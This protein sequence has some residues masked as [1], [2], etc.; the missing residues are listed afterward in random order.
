[1]PLFGSK[2]KKE[3]FIGVD[4]GMSG[5]KLVELVNEKK[6]AQ[7][8][9]YAFVD[10]PGV[11]KLYLED[12]E[13]TAALIKKIV[14][15]AKC[16]TKKTVSALPIPSVFSSIV[17]VGDVKDKEF[18][19]AV[20]AQAKKLVPMPIEETVI[21]YKKIE[22][23]EEEGKKIN[24]V[25]ITAAPKTLVNRY[26]EIFKKADLELVSLETELFALLL[27]KILNF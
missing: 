7:L 11:D 10:V 18:E 26:T 2:D 19:A 24:R 20:Y 1:M 3:S 27:Q 5:I 9:T 12:P 14:A 13:K 8:Q 25:L 17:S 22:M 16:T 21:D 6:R 23:N 15:K 4:L